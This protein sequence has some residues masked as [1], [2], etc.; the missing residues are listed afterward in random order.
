M[1][2]K[3]FYCRAYDN[4]IF[5]FHLHANDT[6]HFPHGAQR[7]G[8]VHQ[9][10]LSPAWFMFIFVCCI[11]RKR[12]GDLGPD[13]GSLGGS[14]DGGFRKRPRFEGNVG[15]D[16]DAPPATLRVLVRNMDAGG[17]I[18]KVGLMSTFY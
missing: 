6:R 1:A 17:I 13:E 12:S 18:G 8:Y 2:Y 16:S 15:G 7:C 5:H 4:T 14:G 11:G 9:T 3:C 10:S